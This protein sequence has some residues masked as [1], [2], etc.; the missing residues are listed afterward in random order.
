MKI[1]SQYIIR[2]IAGEN[3]L[4]NQGTLDVDMTKIISLNGTACLL[5]EEL[6]GK[7][8]T[9]QDAAEILMKRYDIGRE[10][11]LHDVLSWINTLKNCGVI[12]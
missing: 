8:F 12:E 7:D 3:I 2:E 1:N 5:Y 10:Q 4:I 9:E 11:A 6:S